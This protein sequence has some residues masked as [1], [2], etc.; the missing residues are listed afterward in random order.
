MS[1]NILTISRIWIWLMKASTTWTSLRILS[2]PP[3]RRTPLEG[4]QGCN[5]PKFK[6]K[7]LKYSLLNTSKGSKW[8]TI[9]SET[10]S[11]KTRWPKHLSLS[12]NNGTTTTKILTSNLLTQLLKLKSSKTKPKW[13]KNNSKALWPCHKRPNRLMINFWKKEISTKCT[14]KECKKIRKNS[15]KISKNSTLYRINTT[16]NTMSLLKNTTLQ[17]R[18]KCLSRSNEINLKFKLKEKKRPLLFLLSI[19]KKPIWTRPE[20]SILLFQ[21]KKI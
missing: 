1:L 7:S 9:S 20:R 3:S 10:F 12:K 13:C 5:K 8:L 6:S 11:F 15:M 21:N 19:P 14:T 17:W 2:T 4:C 18:K 16:R